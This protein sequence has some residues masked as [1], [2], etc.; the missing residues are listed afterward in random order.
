MN[1]ISILI[2]DDNPNFAK[3][4]EEL[5]LTLSVDYIPNFI[6]AQNLAEAYEAIDQQKLDLAIVDLKLRSDKTDSYEGN[7]AISEIIEKIR[8]PIIV[9]S[10]TIDQ[11]DTDLSS[12]V[13]NFFKRGCDLNEIVNSISGILNTGI[14][15]LLGGT[16]LIEQK[17][18]EIFWDSF[19][20]S[21]NQWEGQKSKLVR[22]FSVHLH[23]TLEII[24]ENS[25]FSTLEFYLESP[26]KENTTGNIYQ[27]DN[28]FFITLT[29][30]CDFAQ[31]KAENILL[32]KLETS[33]ISK[34]TNALHKD[35]LTEE[36]K[37][38]KTE[39]VKNKLRPLIENKKPRFHYMPSTKYFEHSLINFE[40]VLHI[41]YSDLKDT[42]NKVLTVSPHF[43]KDI[44][45]RFSSYF[46]RQGSPDFESNLILNDILSL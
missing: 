20:G 35:S 13:H 43:T 4:L 24:E 6:S 16:G 41:P 39:K 38:K 31:S 36:D 11:I 5:Y 12:K 44:I 26:V 19:A 40:K 2:L 29:P 34:L 15:E 21:L 46:S 37:K 42:Y 45:N 10:S 33:E 14:I 22:H 3:D 8:I 18:N 28:D 32:L 25:L 1:N 30:S 9:H 23:K 7:Q 17:I 27:K